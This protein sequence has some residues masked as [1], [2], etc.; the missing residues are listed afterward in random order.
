MADGRGP[1]HD[2]DPIRIYPELFYA[3]Q[4]NDAKCLVDLPEVNVGGFKTGLVQGHPARRHGP[5][6]HNGRIHSGK[7]YGADGG[8]GFNALLLSGLLGHK[9]HRGR[10]SVK[11]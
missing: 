1:A 10:C 5:G 7:A 6:T 8:Q 2:V 11:R 9:Q 4:C 3:V